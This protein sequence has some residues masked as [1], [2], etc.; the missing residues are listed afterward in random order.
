M[1]D[2]LRLA[3]EITGGHPEVVYNTRTERGPGRMCADLSLAR[4]KLG[5]QPTIRLETGL[6]LTLERAAGLR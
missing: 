5:Y 4:E 1:C 3:L 6:R 2:L